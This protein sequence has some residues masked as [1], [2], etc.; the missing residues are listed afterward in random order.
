[1]Y[2]KRKLSKQERFILL[3]LK[4]NGSTCYNELRRRVAERLDLEY[5]TDSYKASFSR[6]IGGLWKQKLIRR[7]VSG[8]TYGRHVFSSYSLTLSKKGTK[9]LSYYLSMT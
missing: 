6:C 1:M 8:F 3:I 4:G 9:I 2:Y 7:R 5:E